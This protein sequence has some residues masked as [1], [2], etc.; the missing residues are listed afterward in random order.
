[1]QQDKNGASVKVGDR[2]TIECV[3]TAIQ[4]GDGQCN[5]D[6]E[7]AEPLKRGATKTRFSADACQVTRSQSVEAARESIGI[8][9]PAAG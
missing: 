8:K 2:V 6:L 9:E 3:V 1:M 5:L 7:T 4:V